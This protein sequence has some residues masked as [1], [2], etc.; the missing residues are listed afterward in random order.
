MRWLGKEGS[1]GDFGYDARP[2]VAAT[3]RLSSAVIPKGVAIG[4]AAPRHVEIAMPSSPIVI[5]ASPAVQD[6]LKWAIAFVFS[7]V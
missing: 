3:P 2:S 7:T 4:L 6:N 5:E 1:W